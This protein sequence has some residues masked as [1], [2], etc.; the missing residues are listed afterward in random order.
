MI[1][2]KQN[3]L[4][5][6]PHIFFIY[7][8]FYFYFI[9]DIDKTEHPSRL[10]QQPQ[11]GSCSFKNSSTL[12]DVPEG[13][14]FASQSCRSVDT[15]YQFPYPAVPFKRGGASTAP[16]TPTG[17]AVTLLP[18]SHS[19]HQLAFG[20]PLSMAPAH[21]PRSQY[22]QPMTAP[23]VQMGP[24]NFMVDIEEESQREVYQPG[25]VVLRKHVNG[26]GMYHPPTK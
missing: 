7:L 4:N 24:P 11:N 20:P 22:S 3:V 25:V 5:I 10:S 13:R 12:P 1:S 16:T 18:H 23:V 2:I 15:G 9:C 21:Q 8:Y 14:V 26:K 6:L 17:D 19:A